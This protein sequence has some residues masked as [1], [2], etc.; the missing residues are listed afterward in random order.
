MGVNSRGRCFFRHVAFV[1]DGKT[2]LNRT[3]AAANAGNASDPEL[4]PM[5]FF[6][7]LNSALGGPWPGEPTA[8][9]ALPAY[10]VVDYVR[11]ARQVP[12]QDV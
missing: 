7:I 5:P 10:H 3:S 4:W 8:A 6:L 11:V 9:T 12:P 1:V 2:V